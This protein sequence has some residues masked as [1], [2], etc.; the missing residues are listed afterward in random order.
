MATYFTHINLPIKLYHKDVYIPYNTTVQFIPVNNGFIHPIFF[1]G[2]ST[3]GWI[4]SL[5][6]LCINYRTQQ[7]IKKIHKSTTYC[8]CSILG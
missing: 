7:Y 6:L 8:T 5:P 1:M 3:H 2:L 4:K